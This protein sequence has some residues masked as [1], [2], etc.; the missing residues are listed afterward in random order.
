MLRAPLRG[1][2][3][4]QGRRALSAP[5][6]VL[7][8]AFVVLSVAF[9]AGSLILCSRRSPSSDAAALAGRLAGSGHGR[10]GPSSA[11][12]PGP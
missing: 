3:A 4:H 11:G 5:A 10:R 1:F 2:L 9:V 7:S 12:V 8:V 6:V